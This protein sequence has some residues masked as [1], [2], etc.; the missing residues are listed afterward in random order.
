MSEIDNA[1]KECDLMIDRIIESDAELKE[2]YAIIT[3]IKG[4]ARQNGAC[5]LIFTNNFRRFDL[6]ARKNSLLLWCCPVWKRF[7]HKYPLSG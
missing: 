5:L 2:N 7:R 1:I 4:V 6:D 3:S